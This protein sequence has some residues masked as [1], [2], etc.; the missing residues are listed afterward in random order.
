MYLLLKL[1]NIQKFSQLEKENNS[2]IKIICNEKDIIIRIMTH[3][4]IKALI[5]IILRI[6]DRNE[7]DNE[8]FFFNIL[9]LS[10]IKEIING[11]F[12]NEQF[13]Q[14][15]GNLLMFATNKLVQN[16]INVNVLFI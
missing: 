9:V 11:K 7:F 10:L 12:Y 3:N 15:L 14:L 2:L 4:F 8:N 13:Y 5:M 16:A 6:A 1:N